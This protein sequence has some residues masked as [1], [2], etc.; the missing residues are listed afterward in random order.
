MV[1]ELK[2][3]LKDKEF[4]DLLLLAFQTQKLGKQ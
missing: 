4:L 2:Q 1:D 3:N